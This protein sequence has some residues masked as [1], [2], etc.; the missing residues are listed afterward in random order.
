MSTTLLSLCKAVKHIINF[1][2]CV[3]GTNFNGLALDWC[4]R[5]IIL[6]CCKIIFFKKTFVYNMMMMMMMMMIYQIVYFQIVH[7]W[8]KFTSLVRVFKRE[9]NATRAF[10]LLL[11]K[12]GAP[13]FH[14][15]ILTSDQHQ[16][17]LMKNLTYQLNQQHPTTVSMIIYLRTFLTLIYGKF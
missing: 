17:L 4:I 5:K 9:I 8:E 15:S 10:V 13:K 3:L 14:V 7:T 2:E 12:Y 16:K 11:V 6:H 1:K